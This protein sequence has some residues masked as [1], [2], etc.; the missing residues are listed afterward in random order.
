MFVGALPCS[1]PLVPIF[2]DCIRVHNNLF[3]YKLFT[4][5]S[6]C[7]SMI[8]EPVIL[9]DNFAFCRPIEYFIVV[10]KRPF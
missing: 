9:G 5:Y 8:P 4:I 10:I 2:H 7:L 6:I 1:P 3:L